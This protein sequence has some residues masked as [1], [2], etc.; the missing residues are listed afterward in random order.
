[1]HTYTYTQTQRTQIHTVTS[2]GIYSY[3]HVCMYD[4]RMHVLFA[5]YVRTNQF[6]ALV[7]V[8]IANTWW[9]GADSKSK[10]KEEERVRER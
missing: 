10:E 4:V 6:C 2:V 9:W 3:M 7:E 8:Q 1:M 5:T